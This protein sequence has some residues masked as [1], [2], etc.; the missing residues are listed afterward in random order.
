MGWG[1]AERLGAIRAPTVVVHGEEDSF[2]PVENGRKIAELIPDAKYVELPGVG[3]LVPH[4]AP[5]RISELLMD[6]VAA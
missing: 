3:H 5:E 2:I 6:V 1:H 4:E